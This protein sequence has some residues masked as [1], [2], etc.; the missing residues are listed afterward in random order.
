MRIGEIIAGQEGLEGL[1]GQEGLTVELRPVPA[2]PPFPPLPPILSIPGRENEGNDLRA[3]E[4]VPPS[5]SR[6]SRRIS[7]AEE[8]RQQSL[9][10]AMVV[11]ESNEKTGGEPEE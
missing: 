8:V 5:A 11:E 1:E 7:A 2:S 3:P 4:F 9:I 6:G 10:R